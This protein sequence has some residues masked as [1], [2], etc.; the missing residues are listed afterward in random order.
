[1]KAISVFDFTEEAY[2]KISNEHPETYNYCRVCKKRVVLTV[3]PY[4][5]RG[6]SHYCVEHCPKHNWQS[7][8]DYPTHC[9]ICG[10]DYEEYLESVLD[11]HKIEYLHR[12]R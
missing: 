5:P 9:Q 2:A 7:D 6:T 3:S 10:I 12:G 11:N 8:F 4:P 1:M